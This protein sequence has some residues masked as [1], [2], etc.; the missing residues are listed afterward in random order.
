MQL[1]PWTGRATITFERVRLPRRDGIKDVEFAAHAFNADRVKSDTHR[2]RHPI[3]PGLSPRKGNAYVV[4]VGVNAFDDPKWDLKFAAAD[5]RAMSQTLGDSLTKSGRYGKVVVVPLVSDVRREEGKRAVAESTATKANLRA[6]LDSLAGGKADPAFL[7]AVPAAAD[8]REA[9][10]EDLVIITFSTHGY[11]GGDGRF[12]LLPADIGADHKGEVSRELLARCISTDDL[13]AW[14]RGVDAGEMVMVVDACQSAGSVEQDGFKP[15]P[16]GSRGLGQLAY[17]KRMRILAASQA[18]DVAFE[19]PRIG[20]GLLTYALCRDGL[21][22]GRADFEPSDKKFSIGEW[23]RYGVKRVPE[24]ADDI[25]SGKVGARSLT[26][27]A[28]RKVGKQSVAQLPSLFDFT[29][30]SGGSILLE[31]PTNSKPPMK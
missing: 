21:G 15:G 12:Y 14:L 6:T 31:L 18:A 20:H 1:H 5:A 2:V 13:S 19:D 4:C 16:M 29:K 11:N 27:R 30:T 9:R 25:A 22:L 10:P 28:L 7:K 17:D 26:E 8:L 23:L 24:L 3:P